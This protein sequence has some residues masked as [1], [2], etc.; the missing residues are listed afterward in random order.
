MASRKIF[1][2]FFHTNFF[3]F[4]LLISNHTVF[5]VQFA[6]SLVQINSKLNE[7][8]RMITYTKFF[9]LTLNLA[10]S[11]LHTF[12]SKCQSFQSTEALKEVLSRI[13]FGTTSASCGDQSFPQLSYSGNVQV[14]NFSALLHDL[15]FTA[16]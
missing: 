15:N 12:S 1:R 2:H 16:F 13:T 14:H 10:N 6:N 9:S 3:M 5:L 11:K 7:K 8:N 4:I